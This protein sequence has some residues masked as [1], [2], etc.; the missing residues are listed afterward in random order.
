MLF[1]ENVTNIAHVDCEAS[2][3]PQLL[4]TLKSPLATWAAMRVRGT[5]PALV[6]VSCWGALAVF[7]CWAAKPRARGVSVSVAGLVPVPE[8]VATWVPT[9][10]TTVRVPDLAPATDGANAIERVQ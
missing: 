2:E 10:S 5:P 4:T 9:L 3:F 1:G 6:R 7:S 8:S